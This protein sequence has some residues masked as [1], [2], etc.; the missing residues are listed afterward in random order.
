MQNIYSY[1]RATYT[2]SKLAFAALLALGTAATAQAQVLGYSPATAQNVRTTY[3]DLGSTGTVI[4]TA[5]NDDAAST[6]QE[7]GF[8]FTF[9][10]QSFTQFTLSTNGFIKLGATGFSAP[11]LVNPLGSRDP[12]DVNIIAPSSYIDLYGAQDQTANPTSFRVVTT[13]AVGS[14]VCTIQFKNL[15]DKATPGT[16]PAPDIPAQMNTMQFQIKLYEGTNV[17]DFVYGS[18]TASTG[19]ATGQPFIIGLKGTGPSSADYLFA[20]KPSSQFPW[21]E[22]TFNNPTTELLPHFV[23]NTFLPDAGRTYRFT[24][25][26]P[27]DAGVA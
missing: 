25:A 8:S 18:W 3:T 2:W 17:I 14:R 12:A 16:P 20:Y 4:T 9:N 21:S 13:G 11:T 6:A 7:I 19:A 15:R 26:P 1:S 24:P 5:N 23:R 10:S 27:N 22:T